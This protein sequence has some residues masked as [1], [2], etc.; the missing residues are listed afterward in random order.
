MDDV[1]E[2]VEMH[3]LT[4]CHLCVMGE[5]GECHVP[6]CM[7]WCADA[8]DAEEAWWLREVLGLAHLAVTHG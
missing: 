1:G 7:F 2:E 5:G 6:G 3:S 4:V 8:P